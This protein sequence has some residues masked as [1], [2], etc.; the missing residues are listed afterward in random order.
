MLAGPGDLLLGQPLCILFLCPASSDSPGRPTLL[1]FSQP[2]RLGI[3]GFL[4]WCLASPTRRGCFRGQEVEAPAPQTGLESG[5]CHAPCAVGQGSYSAAQFLGEEWRP[6][7]SGRNVRV[8]DYLSSCSS[9]LCCS[10]RVF[11]ILC[12]PFK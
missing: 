7:C 4:Q 11:L 5:L 9:H 12:L 2:S 1:G 8:C 3:A 6:T 10:Q